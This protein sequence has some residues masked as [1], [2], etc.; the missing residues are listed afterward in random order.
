MKSLHHVCE[1]CGSDFVIKYDDTLCE[2]DP[3]HCPFC[4]EYIVDPEEVSD[5]DD[6]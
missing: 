6:E 2:S 3:L 5:E 4:A 1:N